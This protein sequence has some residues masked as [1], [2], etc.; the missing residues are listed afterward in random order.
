MTTITKKSNDKNLDVIDSENV[1]LVFKT[2]KGVAVC[3]AQLFGK[4][5]EVVIHDL[6][7]PESSIIHIEN[8][9]VSGRKVGG[10]IVGGPDKDL[11]LQ[12][13][14]EYGSGPQIQVYEMTTKA[15]VKLKASTVLFRNQRGIPF[16]ALCINYDLT[17]PLALNDWLS[18]LLPAFSQ[19]E[20]ITI[21]DPSNHREIDTSDAADVDGILETL[22][23]NSLYRQLGSEE[24]LTKERRFAVV[25]ELE[26]KGTFL[27]KGAVS[28]VANVLNV[29]KF[30][31]YND[32]DEIR[33]GR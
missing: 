1:E 17:F 27:I 29:S 33:S 22:I 31:I 16:A 14:T 24:N 5:C 30:T 9:H 18:E 28:R 19:N 8:S 4:T 3:I 21:S 11:F 32:I 25:R 15:G 26:E 10:P 12:W 23:Q 6:R 7:T 2:L 13:L 20:K